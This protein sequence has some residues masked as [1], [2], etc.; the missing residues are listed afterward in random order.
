MTAR[1]HNIQQVYASDS[2]GRD[3]VLLGSVQTVF[4]NG[5]D[6]ESPFAAHV[7]VEGSSHDIG[8]PRLSFMQVFA[9]SLTPTT[10]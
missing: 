6:L 3:L 10:T 5:K 7:V 9:V 2:F 8:E 4:K 1:R